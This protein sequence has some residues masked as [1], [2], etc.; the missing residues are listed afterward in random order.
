MVQTRLLEVAIREFGSKGLDGASTRH[1][2]GAANTAMSSITYHFGGKEGLYLA[3]A[4]HIAERMGIVVED[5]DLSGGDDP[6]GAREL[7]KTMLSRMVDKVSRA[8]NEALFIVREQMNPTEAFERIWGGPMGRMWQRM[9]QLVCVASG[10][11]DERR[12]RIVALTLFGQ[13]IALRASRAS[14]ERLSGAS[15]DDAALLAD[16][17]S[18]ILANA[19]AI[20]DRLAGNPEIHP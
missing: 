18:V 7:V 10:S 15:L 5:L 4:D 8:E 1:I 11:S 14:F 20:L 9:A 3:A 2:A 13:A 12:C 16:V 17:K 6:A 19:D